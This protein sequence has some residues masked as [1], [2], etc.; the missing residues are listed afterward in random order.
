MIPKKEVPA[1]YNK[2][3]DLTSH[4]SIDNKLKQHVT[5]S[6]KYNDIKIVLIDV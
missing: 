3:N 4:Y 5:C 6:F 1:N 2:I